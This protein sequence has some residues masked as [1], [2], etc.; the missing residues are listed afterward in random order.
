VQT[1]TPSKLSKKQI[2]IIVG[3]IMGAVTAILELAFG[4][5]V[6]VIPLG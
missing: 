4:I 5:D 6:P 2:G 3:V 1:E